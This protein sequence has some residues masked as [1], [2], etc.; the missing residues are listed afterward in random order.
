MDLV[1]YSG[2][3]FETPES[4]FIEVVLAILVLV[5]TVILRRHCIAEP[6]TGADHLVLP[7]G[8]IISINHGSY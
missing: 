3:D 5:L 1:V 2:V 4:Y 8:A 7:S 6:T